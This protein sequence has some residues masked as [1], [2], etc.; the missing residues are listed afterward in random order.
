LDGK[1]GVAGETQ[2]N[3][4]ANLTERNS[5]SNESSELNSRKYAFIMDKNYR[6][7]NNF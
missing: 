1:D 4:N 3:Q 2:V 6:K 5:V 7:S